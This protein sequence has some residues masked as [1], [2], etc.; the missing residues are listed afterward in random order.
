MLFVN[1]TRNSHPNK[2][3]TFR[4]GM[5]WKLGRAIDVDPNPPFCAYAGAVQRI[6]LSILSIRWYDFALNQFRTNCVYVCLSVCESRRL[7]LPLPT[8]AAA[9]KDI[10]RL[11]KHYL[12]ILLSLLRLRLLP[13]DT[14]STFEIWFKFNIGLILF[15]S[16]THTHFIVARRRKYMAVSPVLFIIIIVSRHKRHPNPLHR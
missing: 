7:P 11:T 13:M 14:F 5:M 6:I 4:L 10:V 9:S 12:I 8:T 2:I 16:Q 15:A 3:F 1:A